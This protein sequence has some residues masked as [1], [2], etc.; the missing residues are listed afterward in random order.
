MVTSPAGE[1]DEGEAEDT[2]LGDA[3][4]GSGEVWAPPALAVIARASAA[5]HAIAAGAPPPVARR[6]HALCPALLS[7]GASYADRHGVC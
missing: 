5:A 6:C 7:T 2:T 3:S 1:A 4:A